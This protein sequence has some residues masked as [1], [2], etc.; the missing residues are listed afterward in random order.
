MLSQDLQQLRCTTDKCKF[1]L[2]TK[3][4][5]FSNLEINHTHLLLVDSGVSKLRRDLD[6]HIS[7]NTNAILFNVLISGNIKDI[8]EMI[9]RLSAGQFVIICADS[10]GGAKLVV[11]LVSLAKS[12]IQKQT[13]DKFESDSTH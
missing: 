5:S 2:G 11:D 10:G 6:L 1:I 4:S 9:V 8:K 7:E 3:G 12:V 13:M